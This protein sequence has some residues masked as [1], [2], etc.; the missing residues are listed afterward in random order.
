[1]CQGTADSSVHKTPLQA[2][3]S[4]STVKQVGPTEGAE[5]AIGRWFD[6]DMIITV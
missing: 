6:L 2:G 5:A 1:M 3:M 4:N